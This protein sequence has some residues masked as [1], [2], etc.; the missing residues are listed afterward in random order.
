MIQMAVGGWVREAGKKDLLELI[1]FLERHAATMPR[2][3]L[4]YA[5]EHL[6]AQQKARFMGMKKAG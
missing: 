4:R 5:I 6:D 3:T 1:R 2:T